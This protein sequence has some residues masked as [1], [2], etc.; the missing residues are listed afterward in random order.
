MAKSYEKSNE[1]ILFYDISYKTFMR[2]KPSHVRFNQIDGF[3]K[4]YDG[5][6]YLILFRPERYDAIYVR[7]RYLASQNIT[8]SIDH[9]F[10]RMEI[11]SYNCLSIEKRFTFHNV[12]TLYSHL[13]IRIKVTNTIRYF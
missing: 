7:I 2:S 1:N 11:D 4:V 8:F 10:Q 5:T 12:I 13:L 3:V 9:N 6:R